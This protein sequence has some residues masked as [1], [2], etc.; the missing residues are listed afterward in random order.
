VKHLVAFQA[1]QY[2][3][4]LAASMMLDFAQRHIIEARSFEQL[5]PELLGN[6]H[7]AGRHTAIAHFGHGDDGN[8]INCK[9]VWTD[10]NSRPWGKQ[11]PLQCPVCY[12]L[13]SWDNMI[14]SRSTKVFPCKGS[15][16][17]YTNNGW[18][19][20]SCTHVEE[21]QAPPE[22]VVLPK[23]AGRGGWIKVPWITDV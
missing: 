11:L 23:N 18:K 13:R 16:R 9:Y 8:I 21:F 5:I 12:S 6:S 20:T 4:S 17:V 15:R 7:I 19:V 14:R 2:L 1:A 3:S 10:E 22:F